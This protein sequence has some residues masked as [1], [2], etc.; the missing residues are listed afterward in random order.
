MTVWGSSYPPL[1]GHRLVGLGSG[2]VPSIEVGLLILG[3]HPCEGAVLLDGRS[4]EHR[5]WCGF[6]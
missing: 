2:G 6:S 1:E 4:D 3:K 5:G